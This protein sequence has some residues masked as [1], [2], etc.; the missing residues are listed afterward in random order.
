MKWI[1]LHTQQYIKATWPTTA[2]TTLKCFLIW[3]LNVLFSNSGNGAWVIVTSNSITRL[4]C[5]GALSIPNILLVLGYDY[6]TTNVSQEMNY[7]TYKRRSNA[8]T[9]YAITRLTTTDVRFIVNAIRLTFIEYWDMGRHV[10][11]GIWREV[12]LYHAACEKGVGF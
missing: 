9:F 2:G 11:A 1:S 6:Q 4:N 10:C 3:L 12:C 5:I 7:V 8:V